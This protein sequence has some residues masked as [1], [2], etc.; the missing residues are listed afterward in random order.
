MDKI[1][2]AIVA[3]AAAL[4]SMSESLKQ[5]A[6][7]SGTV[8]AA[9]ATKPA[10]TPAPDADPLGASPEEEAAA[11]KAAQAANL[12]KAQEAKAAKAKAD[13]AAKA[14]AEAAAATGENAED[15]GAEAPGADILGGDAE[16]AEEVTQAMLRELGMKLL[17][18][19]KDG[20]AKLQKILAKHKATNLTTL[21]K[22]H[23]ASVFSAV[24]ALIKE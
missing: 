12:K 22:E 17:K 9:P 7:N 13:A 11:K 10:A 15:E 24:K 1:I 20:S 8:S 6:A 18:A 2:N 19:D 5:I 4:T 23:Y 14:A 21:A 3:I 16:P